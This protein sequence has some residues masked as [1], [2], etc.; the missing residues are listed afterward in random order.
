MQLSGSR[1]LQDAIVLGYQLQRVSGKDIDV[2]SC[3]ALAQDELSFRIPSA[4]ETSTSTRE[5]DDI[6]ILHGDHH[7]LSDT[8]GF[9]KSLMELHA[10]T[11]IRNSSQLHS[12]ESLAA[13]AMFNWEE[14][15]IVARAP[16]RF[17]VMGGFGDY[18]GSLLLQV[19]IYIYP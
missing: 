16:G 6:E 12:R 2:P 15:I 1:R 17:D 5:T 11:S 7:N 9:L 4:D 8:I 13:A 19:L 18:S 3:Y 10:L 14:E